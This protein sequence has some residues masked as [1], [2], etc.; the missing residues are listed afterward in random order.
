MREEAD[1][2][3]EWVAE[4]AKAPLVEARTAI[5]EAATQHTLFRHL[6]REHRKEGR[7]SYVEIDAPLELYALVRLLRPRHVIE[8]GVSSGVSSAYLLAALERNGNGTLHSVDRPSR[9]RSTA[10]GRG[11]MSWSL[12]PGRMPGWAIPFDLKA[13]W[14]LR[15]GDKARVLPLLAEDLSTTEL[16]VYDVP[17]E[18]LQ[19]APEFRVL[20]PLLPL[21][22][23]ALV[24]HGSGGGLCPA[25]GEWAVHRGGRAVQRAG[26]GLFGMRCETS[27]STRRPA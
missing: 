8:V 2:D 9:P 15:L 3:P 1:P 17:H 14:N 12:P 27:A 21:G 7:S 4:L 6:A 26:L 24:D 25:L 22:A 23:V 16:F 10:R 13:R 19:S 18:C 20:D 5:A 11:G